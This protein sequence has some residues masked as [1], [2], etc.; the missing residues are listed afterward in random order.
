MPSHVTYAYI[1]QNPDI[2]EYI[3]RV[4]LSLS[5]I[6]YTE[7]S[8]SHVEKVAQTAAMILETLDYSPRK[9]ELT[10]IAGFLHDI[11]NVINRTDHAQSGA[12]MAFRLLDRLE[13]PVQE[14]CSIIS[15][16]GNHDEGT[17]QPVDGIS[18]ALIIA[19]KTDVRRSRVRNT[20]FL[21]FDIHDRV[22]YAVE[23]ANLH[24]SEDLRAII[25]ELKIDTEIS[26]V[27]EYF[28]I[29]MER[30][31]LCKRAALFFDRKFKLYING[32]NIL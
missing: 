28:E 15:A 2:R 22:N 27:L 29:F 26:S 32:S 1:R 18:A 24:F 13:M 19:D 12:V 3:R 5:A 23:Y 10:R 17:A 20:D 4:D 14:I 30:M 6:G 21:T 9:V 31:L 25:L 11:G 16:I 8:F 7:H